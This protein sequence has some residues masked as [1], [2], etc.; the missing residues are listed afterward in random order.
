MILNLVFSTRVVDMDLSLHLRF[1]GVFEC[2]SRILQR[3]YSP[4]LGM[5]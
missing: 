5:A 3:Q 1:V 4:E 2:F